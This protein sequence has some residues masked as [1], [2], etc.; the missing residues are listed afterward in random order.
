MGWALWQQQQESNSG[1]FGL[2]LGMFQK[3]GIPP[4]PPASIEQQLLAAYIA[5]LQVDLLMK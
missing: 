4:L 3:L 1:I 2:S 5:L